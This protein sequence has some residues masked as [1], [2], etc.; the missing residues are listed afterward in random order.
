MTLFADPPEIEVDQQWI[1]DPEGIQAEVSC[2]VH[3]EPKAEVS[4]ELSNSEGTF[5]EVQP[6]NRRFRAP[7]PPFF[8]NGGTQ[9]S[10]RV[11]RD[12]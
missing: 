8:V 10:L 2:H 4:E 3:A 12:F 7:L 11:Q 9:S 1:R 6:S 5:N